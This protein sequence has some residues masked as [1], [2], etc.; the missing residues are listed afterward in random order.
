VVS[1]DS[2]GARRSY[3]QFLAFWKDADPDL[4]V[5]QQARAEYAALDAGSKV[6]H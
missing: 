2:S 4:P 1:G 5:Y 3:E 6:A